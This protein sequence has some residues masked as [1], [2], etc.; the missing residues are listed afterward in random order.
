MECMSPAREEAGGHY[1]AGLSCNC[2]LGRSGSAA[3]ACLKL[4][5]RSIKKIL[6]IN[7]EM[8]HGQAKPSG[9][10][11]VPIRVAACRRP[12]WRKFIS[13]A[14]TPGKSGSTDQAKR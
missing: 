13:T 9:A 10:N 12:T 3:I 8:H 6:T 11:F 14:R 5:H 7:C 2:R 4:H 1:A